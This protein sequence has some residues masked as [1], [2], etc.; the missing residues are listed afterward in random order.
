M[1]SANFRFG[2]RSARMLLISITQEILDLVLERHMYLALD[3]NPDSDSKSG[4]RSVSK[5][6]VKNQLF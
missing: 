2:S 3:G 6:T 4:S 1:N 5:L